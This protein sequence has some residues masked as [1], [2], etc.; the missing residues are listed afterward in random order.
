MADELDRLYDK[1]ERGD[2]ASPSPVVSTGKPDDDAKERALTRR[3]LIA[4]SATG[5]ALLAVG[6]GAGWFV[7]RSRRLLPGGGRKE[8]LPPRLEVG[9]EKHFDIDDDRILYKEVGRFETGFHNQRRVTVGPDDRVFVLG[10]QTVKVFDLSGK[11]RNE[12]RPSGLPHCLEVAKDGRLFMAA[13]DHIE[14]CG[15]DGTLETKWAGLGTKVYMTALVVAKDEVFVADARNREIVKY[16]LEG[17][18]KDRFG[19]KDPARKNP[20]IVVPSPYFDLLLGSDGFLHLINPG[21]HRVERYSLDGRYQS[22]WGKPGIAL[23]RFSG[24]C[25]PVYLAFLRGGEYVTSEK[26]LL[27]VKLYSPE[28]E[29]IGVV[30]GPKTFI[31]KGEGAA[32]NFRLNKGIDVSVDSGNRVVVSSPYGRSIHIF[33]RKRG[34]G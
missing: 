27:R 16:D 8:K 29:F 13:G 26:G 33:E 22:S 5:A 34:A 18:E 1:V 12:I 11:F 19:K 4:G 15:N 30:A 24:C 7:S 3:R 10:D 6:G 2:A 21:R 17:K 23:D 20:G 25:N 31:R 9:I 14:I 28:G 32:A